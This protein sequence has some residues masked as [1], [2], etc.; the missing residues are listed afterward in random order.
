MKITFEDGTTMQCAPTDQ[1]RITV[2]EVLVRPQRIP[3]KLHRIWHDPPTYSK[4]AVVRCAIIQP[5]HNVM[6]LAGLKL[7]AKVDM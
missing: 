4:L 2:T 7:V 3:T 6:T 5:G 1:R